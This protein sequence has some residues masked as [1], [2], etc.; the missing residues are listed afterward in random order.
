M[1]FRQ[2]PDMWFPVSFFQFL[3]NPFF[4]ILVVNISSQPEFFLKLNSYSKTNKLKKQNI[5]SSIL[6][7]ASILAYTNQPI[8]AAVLVSSKLIMKYIYIYIYIYS[9]FEYLLKIYESVRALKN[10]SLNS[11]AYRQWR[12]PWR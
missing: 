6:S 5:T 3:V 4:V 2:F 10:C 7:K 12:Q 1:T 9:K 8:F 11:C